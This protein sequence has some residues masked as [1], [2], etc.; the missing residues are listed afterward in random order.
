MRKLVFLLFVCLPAG[1][2]PAG[3]FLPY[4]FPTVL[5][6]RQFKGFQKASLINHFSLQSCFEPVFLKTGSKR[7]YYPDFK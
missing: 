6:S 7:K 2:S 3:F 1:L 5:L 4:S